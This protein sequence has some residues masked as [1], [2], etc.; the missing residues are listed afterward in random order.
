[1]SNALLDDLDRNQEP[2]GLVLAL[3]TLG[4]FYPEGILDPRADVTGIEVLPLGIASEI[5][6]N[7]P[8]LLASGKAVPRIIK[9]ICPSILQAE[10]L[11]GI[12]ID[13]IMLASRIASHGETMKMEVSCQ[14]GKC[15]HTDTLNVNLQDI[16][17]KYSP[18][19]DEHLS[20]YIVDIPDL[21]QKVCI[22]PPTYSTGLEIIRSTIAIQ[23]ELKGL[24]DVVFD[25]FIQD[26]AMVDK[27]VDAVEQNVVLSLSA[28]VDSIFYVETSTG[29]KV[30]DKEAITEWVMRVKREDLYGVRD[31]IS[32]LAQDFESI[33]NVAYACSN[34]SNKNTVRL[35][36]DP[37][38]LFFY[39]PEGSKATKT[40]PTTS[41]KKGATR[42]KPSKTLQR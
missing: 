18:I 13:A 7:D 35:T 11:C 25:D 22:Q 24:G 2:N 42:R 9:A 8:L 34:C 26:A 23:R 17:F 4:R 5:H 41:K 32:A 28:L 36:L 6:L 37:Q 12:D 10:R 27:Y 1:M 30:A 21:G 19:E 40:S 20:S 33:P 3:P 39:E 16:I 29:Q 31:R 14:S 38:K 15:K